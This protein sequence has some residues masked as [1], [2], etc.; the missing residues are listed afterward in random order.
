M[1]NYLINAVPFIRHFH[2]IVVLIVR[3]RGS[4]CS[5]PRRVIEGCKSSWTPMCNHLLSLKLHV[6][7]RGG[8][9]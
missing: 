5:D 9:V 7:P 8:E 4:N 6:D 3:I 1:L 2:F